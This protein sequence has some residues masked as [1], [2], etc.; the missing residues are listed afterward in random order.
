M[1]KLRLRKGKW[2]IIYY[3]DPYDS[4]WSILNEPAEYIRSNRSLDDY[5]FKSP[6]IANGEE[7]FVGREDIVRPTEP[8]P[9]YEKLFDFYKYHTRD[10]SEKEIIHD[11]CKKHGVSNILKALR[12]QVDTIYFTSV[13]KCL[14]LDKFDALERLI[15]KTKNE[16]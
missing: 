16:Y 15:E 5:Y 13:A 14:L 12:D 10:L 9:S 1:E 2:F 8:L 3:E 6:L 4:K 11:F 7:F